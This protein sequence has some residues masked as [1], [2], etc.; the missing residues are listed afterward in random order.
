MFV[1]EPSVSRNW[2]IG[3]HGLAPE[4]KFYGWGPAPASR[5]YYEVNLYLT[6]LVLGEGPVGA[7]GYLRHL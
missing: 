7:P 6:Y 5:G 1:S 4:S 3:R 2:R